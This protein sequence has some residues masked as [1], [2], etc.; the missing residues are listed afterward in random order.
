MK[1]LEISNLEIINGGGI[2]RAGTV[3][4]GVLAA[5][6]VAAHYGWIV[7]SPWG[8]GFLLGAGVALAAASLYCEFS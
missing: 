3:S 6:G 4:G 1:T 8:A 5:A 7:I 2:C